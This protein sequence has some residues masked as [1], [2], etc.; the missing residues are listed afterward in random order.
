MILE[1]A[2]FSHFEFCF[3][4]RVN[5]YLNFGRSPQTIAIIQIYPPSQHYRKARFWQLSIT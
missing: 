5:I 2:K 3:S 1:D 4:F